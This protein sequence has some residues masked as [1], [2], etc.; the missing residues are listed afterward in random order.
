MHLRILL[1]LAVALAL[2]A[3]A[4][5]GVLAHGDLHREIAELSRAI[6][7]HPDDAR[8]YLRRGEIQGAHQEW[9]AAERDIDWA[10]A[11][12][13]TLPEL[14]LARAR[15]AFRRGQARHAFPHVARYME[16]HADSQ[17]GALLY[18]QIR[19]GPGQAGRGHPGAGP[20]SRQGGAARA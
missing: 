1:T 13:S 20:L 17:E 7:E 10:A 4:P 19:G 8:L 9:R 11:M 18:A 3:A 12:D 16:G 14:D 5:G 2:A 6:A 15:L